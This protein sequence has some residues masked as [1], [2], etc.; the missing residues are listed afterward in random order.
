MNKKTIL[1]IPSWYPNPDDVQLG[2]FIQNQIELVNDE[3]NHVVLYIQG[4]PLSKT[5]QTTVSEKNNIQLIHVTYPSGKSIFSRL[6]NFLN[7]VTAGLSK[8]IELNAKVEL[9]HCHVANKNLW[10]AQKYFDTTPCILTEHW[11]GFLNGNFEASP[12]WKQRLTLK[13]INKCQQI[14]TVSQSLQKK[15]QSLGVTRPIKVIRNPIQKTIQKTE[16]NQHNQLR[17]LFIGDLVDKIKNVSGILKA[18]KIALTDTPD[19][20]LTIIGD[21]IDR[22]KLQQLV[23]EMSLENH[24]EFKGRLAQ[25]EVIQIY[26]LYDTLLVNSYTETYSM[27][28]LEALSAGIPVIATKCGGPEQFITKANGLLISINNSQELSEAISAIQQNITKYSPERIRKSVMHYSN[29]SIKD[30]LIN[31]YNSYLS[32]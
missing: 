7:S 4:R 29:D 23:T 31:H 5:I 2:I 28:T 32:Q 15:L 10:I 3:F 12:K 17:L 21:G 20:T 24:V 30:Q 18:L 11:S 22:N 13:R 26:A 6:R 19:I 9:V 8:L 14:F 16:L 1:H 27:V 25:Q